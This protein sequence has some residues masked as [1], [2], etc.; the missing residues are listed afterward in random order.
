[1]VR[2]TVMAAWEDRPATYLQWWPVSASPE[3]PEGRL[4]QRARSASTCSTAARTP[5]QGHLSFKPGNTDVM[6]VSWASNATFPKPIVRWGAAPDALTQTTA[7]TSDTFTSA[8]FATEL[9]LDP[10]SLHNADRRHFRYDD[11]LVAALHVQRQS[12]FLCPHPYRVVPPV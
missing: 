1:M 4:K 3:W 5:L 2:G 7:A 12:Y 10:G 11:I 6:T 9:F 8:D